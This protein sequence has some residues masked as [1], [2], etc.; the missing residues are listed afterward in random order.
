MSYHLFGIRHH[1]PG[2]ARSLVAALD[3]L[4]PDVIVM[5][6]PADAESVLAAAVHP[7]MKPPVAMLM[8]A[9]DDAKQ[10]VFYP[11]AVFSP[12]WQALQW[13]NR[14]QVPVRLMDLP[15]CHQLAMHR[16]EIEKEKA[17]AEQGTTEDQ[18]S[19]SAA[20]PDN[21]VASESSSD[22]D[23][24]RDEAE[25]AFRLDPLSKFAE[26][27]GFKDH[28]LWWEEQIERR[29]QAGDLFTAIREAMTTVRAEAQELDAR[30][31]L[32]ESYMRKVLRETTAQKYERIAVICGAWHVP[33]L[34][35]EAI[36]GKCEGMRAKDDNERLKGLPKIKVQA[37]WIPWTYS[38][39]T[40]NSGYG[41]GVRSPGWYAHL[42]HSNRQA[43]VR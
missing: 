23:A 9:A 29:E 7:A 27:A 3:E 2:C 1:G 19:Q 17:S 39:M 26:A 31:R 24:S 35:E 18:G 14:H 10:S 43:G 38:R 30:D 25:L 37:T 5:E 13:A 6:G 32:R 12:E 40:R 20:N 16:D 33:A 21:L 22:A 36:A 8:Y 41:A 11:L 34:T 15:Q 42:W 28:E 4:R